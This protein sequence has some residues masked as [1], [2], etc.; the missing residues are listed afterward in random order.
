MTKLA[1]KQYAVIDRDIEKGRSLAAICED[2][3]VSRSTVYRCVKRHR[4]RGT[5]EPSKPPGRPRLVSNKAADRALDVML[6][7]EVGGTR[8]V[9]KQLVEER[10]LPRPVAHTTVL[11]RAKQR[12]PERSIKLR[13]KRGAPRKVLTERNK[14]QR[15]AFAKAHLNTDWGRVLFT[16]RCRFYHKWPGQRVKRGVWYDA[17]KG[18]PPGVVQPTKPGCVNVYGGM[19]RVG[20]TALHCV[21]GSTK[22][23][24]RY[25]TQKKTPARNIT[26]AEYREVLKETL[27]PE[28]SRLLG[29]GEEPQW[30]LQQDNDPCHRVAA[31]VVAEWN[32]SRR[33]GHVQL[34][35]D[36]PPNSPDLNPIENL[37]GHVSTLAAQVPCNT[38]TEYEAVVRKLIKKYPRWELENSIGSMK[39]RLQ[40]VIAREGGRTDY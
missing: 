28:G 17:N 25:M 37:W 14:K 31:D 30:T 7:N 8:F 26:A 39:R 21:A 5:C 35:P 34:L 19:S 16:D 13:F 33:R 10:L 23:K 9:R 32:R 20:T 15:L 22:H 36:W 40:Q 27:L 11:R 3:D 18:K 38:V 6:D 1:F 12:A 2:N 29:V 4:L 24:T